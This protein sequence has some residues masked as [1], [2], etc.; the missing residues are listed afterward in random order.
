[1]KKIINK[2]QQKIYAIWRKAKQHISSFVGGQSGYREILDEFTLYRMEK[3]GDLL[4]KWARVV[5]TLLEPMVFLPIATG[6]VLLYFNDC[7]LLQPMEIIISFLSA[8]GIGIGVNHFSTIF[9]EQKEFLTL[10]ERAEFTVRIL[11]DRINSIL[12]SEKLIDK[13]KDTVESILTTMDY[14]KKYYKGADTSKIA[15]HR[16]LKKELIELETD[17]EKNISKIEQIKNEIENIEMSFDK[18][19]VNSYLVIS[20]SSVFNKTTFKGIDE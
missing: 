5:T 4:Q 9:R 3:E 14:W 12:R 11:N 6:I 15:Y 10:K 19:G 2:I 13:D 8:F 18:D 7:P 20:G 17:E 16:K 1:M